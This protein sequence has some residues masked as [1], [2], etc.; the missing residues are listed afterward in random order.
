MKSGKCFSFR[1]NVDELKRALKHFLGGDAGCGRDTGIGRTENGDCWTLVNEMVGNGLENDW[2]YCICKIVVWIVLNTKRLRDCSY[3]KVH[4]MNSTF[5]FLF[6]VFCKQVIF[7]SF[8]F[9]ILKCLLVLWLTN[10]PHLKICCCLS[11]V[12]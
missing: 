10:Q 4:C 3:V 11:W 5:C 2:Y 7:D 6:S 1:E 9:E 8:I 12:L